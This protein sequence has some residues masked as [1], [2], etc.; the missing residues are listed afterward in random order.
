[1]RR[2]GCNAHAR[3]AQVVSGGVQIVV[4][5]QLLAKT[6]KATEKQ[7]NKLL[8]HSRTKKSTGGY[9]INDLRILSWAQKSREYRDESIFG[10]EVGASKTRKI[11]GNTGNSHPVLAGGTV[12]CARARPSS[13]SPGDCRSAG[14]FHAAPRRPPVPRASE[15]GNGDEQIDPAQ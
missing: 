4:P 2:G 11:K 1:M 9:G 15:N 12:P 10:V 6:E 7:I 8:P 3:K 13:S 5:L 14:E